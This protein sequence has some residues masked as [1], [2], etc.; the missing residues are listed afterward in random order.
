MKYI[1]FLLFCLHI[2]VVLATGRFAGDVTWLYALENGRCTDSMA[3]DT[4]RKY[5]IPPNLIQR[6]AEL[7]LEFDQNCRGGSTTTTTT[8]TTKPALGERAGEGD[9]RGIG[10]SARGRKGT[11]YNDS[12]KRYS[13]TRSAPMSA[14]PTDERLPYNFFYRLDD[15]IPILDKVI[16]NK[17]QNGD[18]V[19]SGNPC[20]PSGPSSVDALGAVATSQ[21]GAWRTVPGSWDPPLVFER[22]SCVYV[23]LLRHTDARLN[24]YSDSDY[25]V[26]HSKPDMLYV[27]ET[28]SIRQRLAQ[29]RNSYPGRTHRSGSSTSPTSPS[30]NNISNGHST[31][32]N[33]DAIATA[34]SAVSAVASDTAG[35]TEGASRDREYFVAE[36]AVYSAENKSAARL[37]E[38]RCITALKKAGYSVVGGSDAQHVLFKT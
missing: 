11:I 32:R 33:M 25:V 35:K 3:L 30:I 29:H 12:N 1:Y 23:L 17:S 21:A 19:N 18:Q 34:E 27:G 6:A 2:G 4:A 38:A 28:E 24:S 20:G 36:F 22:S 13:A 16:R 7:S 10:R 14:S 8:T 15:V 31:A 9:G 37:L 26:A 5:R